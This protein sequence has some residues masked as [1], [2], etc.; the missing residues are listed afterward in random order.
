[1]CSSDLLASFSGTYGA[2]PSRAS[3]AMNAMLQDHYLRSGA[4]FIKGGGR[5]LVDALVG[6]V[7]DN[8]GE[9]RLRSRVRRILVESGAVR[10]VELAN[11]EVLRSRIVI[12]NADAKRT[13][14]DMVGPQHLSPATAER[15]EETRMALPLFVIYL[16]MKRDPQE[17]GIPN[18]N[19][20]LAS[21]YNIEELY[22]SCYDGELPDEPAVFISIASR[23]DPESANIAPPGYTNLQLMSVAPA[24]LRT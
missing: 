15:A 16:A 9:L 22:A 17:L 5:A 23:K 3:A 13:L 21:A 7:R 2:P 1:M 6:A 12:S 18:T 4:Y 20:L 11:G 14:L 24:A 8:G 10:G 19:Y